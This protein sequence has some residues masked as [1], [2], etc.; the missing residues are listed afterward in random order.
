VF[1]HPTADALADH[2]LRLLAPAPAPEPAGP[3]ATGGRAEVAGLSDAEAE[4]ALLAELQGG[5]VK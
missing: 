4:A 1:D 2:L 3:P 5:G